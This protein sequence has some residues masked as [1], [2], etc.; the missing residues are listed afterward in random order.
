MF[1]YTKELRKSLKDN[2]LSH[3]SNHN[4]QERIKMLSEHAGKCELRINTPRYEHIIF[5]H[6]INNIVITILYQHKLQSMCQKNPERGDHDLCIGLKGNQLSLPEENNKTNQN[7][8][9]VGGVGS[10][11]KQQQVNKMCAK[12]VSESPFLF[13]CTRLGL[14]LAYPQVD[15]VVTN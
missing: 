12:S 15:N 11:H 7:M 8:F 6:N 3:T 9:L 4:R 2:A 1:Q 10:S 13:E 14:N 5:L